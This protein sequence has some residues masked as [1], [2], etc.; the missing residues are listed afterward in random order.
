LSGDR[1]EVDRPQEHTTSP[2]ILLI[3]HKPRLVGL[4]RRGLEFEGFAIEAERDGKEGERRALHDN[5]DLILLDVM[6]PGKGGLE[7]LGSMR[8]TKPSVP[9]ILLSARGEVAD[10]VA[11][12]NAGAVDY[13]VTPFSVSELAARVRAQLRAA[14][15]ATAGVLSGEDIEVNLLTREVR[16]EGRLVQL[17]GTEFELLVYLLRNRGR[18]LSREQILS[19]VWRYEHNPKTNIVNVYIRYLRRKLSFANNPA[20][21]FTVSPLGYRLGDARYPP[22]SHAAVLERYG[23]QADQLNGPHRRKN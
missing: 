1:G 4:V 19:T 9:V 3:E 20:P 21:I 11:G 6:L 5:F 10:R 23:G 22:S 8:Q 2:V 17:S 15:Q 12:L 14:A 7:I 16:R 13:L 18:V